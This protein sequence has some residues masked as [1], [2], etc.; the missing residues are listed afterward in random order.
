MGDYFENAN[1]ILQDCLYALASILRYV[2]FLSHLFLLQVNFDRFCKPVH[3]I[4]YN[5]FI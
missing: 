1:L 2:F 4:C 3:K 5:S